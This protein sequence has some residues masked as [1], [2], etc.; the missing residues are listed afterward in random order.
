MSGIIRKN[1]WHEKDSNPEPTTWEICCPNLT[2]VIFEQ[3]ELAILVWNKK[4]NDTT[5]WK[6]FPTYYICGEK[7]EKAVEMQIACVKSYE[8]INI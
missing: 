7:K 1:I 5:E 4:K 3:K 6:F 8:A 2:A